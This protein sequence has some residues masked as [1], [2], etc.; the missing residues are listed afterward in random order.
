MERILE[1]KV[2]L[3]YVKRYKNAMRFSLAEKSKTKKFVYGVYTFGLMY[4]LYHLSKRK[5]HLLFGSISTRL[6]FGKKM[7]FPATDIGTYTLGMYK[8]SPHGC[9]RKLT[10]WMLKNLKSNDVFYDVG[11]HLGFYTA[12]AEHLISTG[13]VHAFEAN[14]KLSH[15]LRRN[16]TDSKK[17]H[18]IETA[19]AESEGSVDFYDATEIDDSSASSRFNVVKSTLPPKSVKATSLD[20]YIKETK[21]TPTVIKFD[22]EGGEYDAILGIVDFIT[23]NKPVIIME[24]WGGDLG[25]QYSDKAVKKIQE[26]GYRCY[27]IDVRGTLSDKSIQNPVESITGLG[28]HARDNFVFIYST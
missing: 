26:L 10:M 24:I 25:T 1:Q 12:L 15:Y 20:A 19:V 5:N 14:E 22:I 8:I 13:E 11:A 4:V 18:V 2:F 28:E 16:F 6:F 3:D 23:R 9:E 17:V 21:T 7:T 27:S